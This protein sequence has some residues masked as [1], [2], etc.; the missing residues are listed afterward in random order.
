VIGKVTFAASTSATINFSGVSAFTSTTSY[1]CTF[2]NASGTATN[3][4]LDLINTSATQ[5]TI[6]ASGNT[7][8]TFAYIC[9]GN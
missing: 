2:S 4:R 9:I 8:D 6:N 3:V 5:I 1:V 7:S